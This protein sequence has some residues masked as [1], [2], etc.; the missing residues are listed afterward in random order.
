VNITTAEQF[1]GND[2]HVL[3]LFSADDNDVL[4]I[5]GPYTG[6]EHAEAAL[7]QLR[8]WPLDGVWE[9]VKLKTYSTSGKTTTGPYSV[10]WDDGTLACRHPRGMQF[11]D[12]NVQS[13]TFGGVR[14]DG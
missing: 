14:D 1:T 10:S 4:G 11:G 7:E 5:W 2:W 3:V 9:T 6:A 12:S 8:Q 13:N